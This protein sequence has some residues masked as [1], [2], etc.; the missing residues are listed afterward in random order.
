[1]KLFCRKG[2]TLLRKGNETEFD[3]ATR[4]ILEDLEIRG[5]ES[6]GQN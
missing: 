6:Y 1:M 2:I 4:E 3:K 5:E